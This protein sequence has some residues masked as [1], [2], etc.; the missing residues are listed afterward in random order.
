MDLLIVNPLEIPNW[1]ELILSRPDYSFF[2]STAWARVLSEAYGYKPMYFS[3]FDGDRLRALLPLM[4]VRSFLTGKRGVS[5]PFSDFCEPVLDEKAFFPELLEAVIEC[6]KGRDWKYLEIRGGQS[7]LPETP[8]SETYLE[9]VLAL[10]PDEKKAVD[11][12]RNSTWRNVEKAVR[13]GVKVE[14]L[15]SPQALKDFYRLHCESRKRHGFPPQPFTFFRKIQEHIL[16]HGLGWVVLAY[17]D[18]QVVSGNV[19]FHFGKKALYKYGASDKRYQHLR[20]ANLAMYRG[21]KWYGDHGY[22]NLSFGRTD[23]QDEGLEQFKRGWGTTSSLIK[24]YRYD[25][26]RHTFL[27]GGSASKGVYTA[28]FN[29]TPVWL[30]RAVGGALYR[31]MG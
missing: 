17:H 11:A 20:A 18:G 10:M 26:P 5:L 30:L 31:H 25:F 13:N 28:L 16:S 6:G 7:L 14:V 9:H 23:L 4:E 24:Y 8:E 21:I 2:L 12:F 3:V 1:D 29:K 27:Q 19:Y 15:N 22:T